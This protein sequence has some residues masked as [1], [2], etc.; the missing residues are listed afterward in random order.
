MKTTEYDPR[1]HVGSYRTS[2]RRIMP[3]PSVVYIVFFVL[4]AWFSTKSTWAV[5]TTIGSYQLSDWGLNYAGGFIR[6][7]LSGYL[8]LA[9]CHYTELTFAT[10]ATTVAITANLIFV[11]TAAI[12]LYPLR[13]NNWAWLIIYT[14]GLIA[15][16]SLY[17]MIAGHK[18]S[19]LMAISALLFLGASKIQNDK[20]RSIWILLGLASTIPLLLIHE[21]YVVFLPLLFISLSALK[22][23]PMNVIISS[24]I[25]LGDLLSVAASV[26]ASGTISQRDAM[27]TAY[28]DALPV[29]WSLW[30]LS[31][32][33]A[34]WHVGL[35]IHETLNV[36]SDFSLKGL[37]E[38][39]AMLAMIVGPLVICY[40]KT[41]PRAGFTGTIGRVSLLLIAA[42]WVGVILLM[43][44]AI[45][46]TRFF[47]LLAILT[48]FATI[49]RYTCSRRKD[50][51]GFN[52]A[53]SQLRGSEVTSETANMRYGLAWGLIAALFLLKPGKVAPLLVNFDWNDVI[54]VA[55]IS[56]IAFGGA[57]RDRRIRA[58]N[59]SGASLRERTDVDISPQEV[60]S[61]LKKGENN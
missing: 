14:P 5:M 9:I 8:I 54:A 51:I 25:F 34:F 2:L 27:M 7:G 3:L 50:G 20:F 53:L 48:I 36:M 23:T 30:P 29:Q 31:D 61:D 56:C 12:F 45:D 57:I 17:P 18:D 37:W 33:G 6:R 47:S 4:V 40:V 42:S 60:A 41:Q 28:Y 1:K 15:A 44:I 35:N 43:P 55:L 39:P 13:Y 38:L 49:F 52:E 22:I 21:G 26:K 58:V 46:W 10:V 11:V 16:G 32:S 24:I 19:V 59:S